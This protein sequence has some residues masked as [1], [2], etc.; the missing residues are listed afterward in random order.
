MWCF[1]GNKATKR[2]IRYKRR[3]NSSLHLHVAVIGESHHPLGPRYP[4]DHVATLATR[5]FAVPYIFHRVDV[6]AGIPVVVERAQ[7]DQF[8][9]AAMQFDPPRLGQ[10]L[11]RHLP[12]QPLLLRVV[13]ACH[14]TSFAG[15]C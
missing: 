11:D 1:H 15:S 13:S 3:Q 5:P 12:L 6:Q 2:A 14:R 7:A 8:L 4:A 9:A 10:P